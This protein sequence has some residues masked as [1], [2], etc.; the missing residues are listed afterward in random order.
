MNK[1]ITIISL[2][3]VLGAT[4]CTKQDLS[5]NKGMGMLS[6]DMTLAP[7]TRALSE[8]LYLD[9]LSMLLLCL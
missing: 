2:G 4:S 9:F 3:L 6:V 7:R 5:E 8:N 1:F